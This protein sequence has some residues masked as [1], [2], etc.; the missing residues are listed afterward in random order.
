VRRSRSSARIRGGDRHRLALRQRGC[1]PLSAL[2]PTLFDAL[3]AAGDERR[4]R[5]DGILV[6][7]WRCAGQATEAN[8]DPLHNA[9]PRDH[10][11]N[12][13]G[14]T[15]TDGELV[16]LGQARPGSTADITAAR[17]DGIVHAVSEADVETTADSGYQGA[18]GTVRTPIKRPKGRATM[19]GRSRPTPLW[20]SFAPRSSG[21]SPSLSGGAS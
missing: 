5:L 3:E 19:A 14:L 1:R 13:Q 16:F 11:M 4:L 15:T 7:T 21:P 12:L 6:P 8:D 20:P 18:G 10:G 2:V 17:A 9:K